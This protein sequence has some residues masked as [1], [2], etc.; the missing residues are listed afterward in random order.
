[1]C[2]VVLEL[3]RRWKAS[4]RLD[5]RRIHKRCFSLLSAVSDQFRVFQ[6]GRSICCE[7]IV[8]ARRSNVFIGNHLPVQG[9]WLRLK[10]L[11]GPH[12]LAG[13][14][15]ARINIVPD[16]HLVLSAHVGVRIQLV[17]RIC[18]WRQFIF[19]LSPL[20]SLAECLVFWVR[21]IIIEIFYEAFESTTNVA[22]AT[23][24]SEVGE[25]GFVV[26]DSCEFIDGLFSWD[27]MAHHIRVSNILT[28]ILVL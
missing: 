26:V 17:M 14:L 28:L 2:S 15:L 1:M 11:V 13:V 16:H 8:L 18:Y 9:L 4:D 20:D 24:L 21:L 3:V 7:I 10:R 12:F 5:R 22:Q 19:Y 6:I 25:V 23:V 27:L